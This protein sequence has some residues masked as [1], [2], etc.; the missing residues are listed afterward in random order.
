MIDIRTYRM[1]NLIK[2]LNRYGIFLELECNDFEE[3]RRTGSIS[4]Y[5]DPPNMNLPIKPD[6]NIQDIKIITDRYDAVL[7][8]Y[9]IIGVNHTEK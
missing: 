3:L 2:V 7:D 5:R 1:N 6:K 9:K 8:G 4:V